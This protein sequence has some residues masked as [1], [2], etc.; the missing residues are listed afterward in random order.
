MDP[1]ALRKAVEDPPTAEKSYAAA[2]LYPWAEAGLKVY[3]ARQAE[4]VL[5]SVEGTDLGMAS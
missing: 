1:A 5:V 2:V 4:E 3:A